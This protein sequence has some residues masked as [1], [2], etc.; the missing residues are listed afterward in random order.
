MTE[1][2]KIIFLDR[3]GVVNVYR[4]DYVKNLSEFVI[5]SDVGKNLAKLSKSGFKLIVITNQSAIN[6][7]LITKTELIKIHEFM[8]AEL[9]KDG[10]VIDAIYFCPHKP[11]ENCDCR[12][13]KTSLF[14]KALSDFFPYDLKNSWVIGDSISD[15]KAASSLGIKGIKIDCNQSIRKEVDEILSFLK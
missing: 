8:I 3:D 4:T 1:S 9:R 10:C 13:P 15:I 6:R 2:N 7:G 5:I 11:E 14:K 12:K